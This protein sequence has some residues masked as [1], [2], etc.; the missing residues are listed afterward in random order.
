MHSILCTALLCSLASALLISEGGQF[1]RLC[2]LST[3]SISAAQPLLLLT[4][5]RTRLREVY[6]L[7][8]DLQLG[9]HRLAEEAHGLWSVKAAADAEAVLARLPGLACARAAVIELAQAPDAAS[10]VAAVAALSISAPD[11]WSLWFE[12]LDSSQQSNGSWKTGRA[13]LSCALAQHIK[14]P[15]NLFDP[16]TLFVV[17]ETRSCLLLCLTAGLGASHQFERLWASRP[18]TFS[19]ALDT[20]V[21]ACMISML[22]AVAVSAAHRASSSSSSGSDEHKEQS[23]R[24]LDPCVGSGTLTAQALLRGHSVTAFDVNPR[25]AAGAAQNLQYLNSSTHRATVA[26]HDAQ[27]P[28]PLQYNVSAVQG[29]MVNLPW[30]Q[31]LRE[32]EGVV[33][34]ILLNIARTVRAATPVVIA[35]GSS[36]ARELQQLGYTVLREA[37]VSNGK[38]VTCVVT[39]ALSPTVPQQQQ[40]LDASLKSI[41]LSGSGS[42]GSSSRA[43]TDACWELLTGGKTQVRQSFSTAFAHV[44]SVFGDILCTHR[45]LQYSSVLLPRCHF[46]T[47]CMHACVASQCSV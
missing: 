10:L 13:P 21:A 22:T 14:G 45:T 24:L 40:Q 44:L 29:V 17:L 23:L 42:S 19:A 18:F 37:P 41:A 43:T 38:S 26:V 47:L 39:V 4:K 36:L 8:L 35:S 34:G 9:R 5:R 27:Q 6:Y 33:K 30:G 25:C 46:A 12:C 11:G 7:E 28:F 1:P 16:S 3:Q 2:S 20:D 31:N 32:R 15:V